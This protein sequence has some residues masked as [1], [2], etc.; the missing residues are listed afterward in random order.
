[1]KTLKILSILIFY[2]TTL[3]FGQERI[4][5]KPQKDYTPQKGD[6]LKG[7]SK[8]ITNLEGV[9]KWDGDNKSLEVH[10]KMIKY[11]FEKLDI[12]ADVLIG[13]VIYSENGNV[14]FNTINDSNE[15]PTILSTAEI[16]QG[17]YIFSFN[18]PL[19]NKG[20][21]GKLK[22]IVDPESPNTARWKLYNSGGLILKDWDADFSVPDAI[23]LKRVK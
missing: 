1:M 17:E 12:Y 2:S 14:I 8:E 10:F 4:I 21:K 19:K 16:N 7:L 11:H 18:D 22:L 23:I 3:V 20:G 6:Y 13:G 15:N 9:W 5:D